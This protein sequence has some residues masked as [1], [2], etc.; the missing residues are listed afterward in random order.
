MHASTPKLLRLYT[1]GSH[2]GFPGQFSGH[3]TPWL[4][5]KCST[6][7]GV[8]EI[9]RL[10]CKHHPKACIISRISGQFWWFLKIRNISFERSN[11]TE[12]APQSAIEPAENTSICSSKVMHISHTAS[13][14]GAPISGA[15]RSLQSSHRWA[16]QRSCARPQQRRKALGSCGPWRM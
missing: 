6:W 8:W 12:Q 15:S 3:L 1:W 10:W 16:V 13:W 11:S 9:H 5:E 2:E 7:G 4:S 14:Q